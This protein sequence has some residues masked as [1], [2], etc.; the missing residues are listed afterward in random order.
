MTSV[1]EFTMVF[2]ELLEC[3]WKNKSGGGEHIKRLRAI[4]HKENIDFGKTHQEVSPP[5]AH[6]A[7]L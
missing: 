6:Q 2:T 7:I 5:A 1:E 3:M 4:F